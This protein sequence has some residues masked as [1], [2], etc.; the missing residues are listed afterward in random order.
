[1]QVDPRRA[2]ALTRLVKKLAIL[3][4]SLVLML[5]LMVW[6]CSTPKADPVY[7][8]VPSG[9]TKAI[10]LGAAQPDSPASDAAKLSPTP[11]AAQPTPETKPAVIVTPDDSLRGSIVSVNDVGRFVVLKFTLGKIPALDS[12]LYVYRQGVKVAELKVT[13]PRK[14]DHTVADIKSGDCRPDDEVRDR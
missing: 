4:G 14:D 9:S 7:T 3:Q 13:G 12:T 5:V 10:N 8:D 1:M 11:K 2:R 6:S